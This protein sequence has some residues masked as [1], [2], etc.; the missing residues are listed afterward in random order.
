MRMISVAVV[1][2][3]LLIVTTTLGLE[4]VDQQQET[5]KKIFQPAAG[6]LIQQHRRQFKDNYPVLTDVSI[7][8]QVFGSRVVC[9]WVLVT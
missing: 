6:T 1:F 4:A 8:L 2:T 7:Q 5:N 3:W 9:V